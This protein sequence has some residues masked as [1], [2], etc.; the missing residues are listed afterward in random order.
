MKKS[1]QARSFAMGAEIL[2]DRSSVHFRVWA[3]DH[4]S[5]ELILV[6]EIPACPDCKDLPP[7]LILEKDADGYF[8]GSLPFITENILYGFRLDGSTRCYPDPASRFQPQGVNGLSRIIDHNSYTWNDSEWKGITEDN[9]VIYEVHIGTFTSEG[10]WEAARKQLPELA[11][12]GITVIELLPIAEFQ[13]RFNW[14]YDGIFQFAPSHH[15]GT[16]DELR[17]F[18]DQAHQCGIGVILDVVYN[19]LGWGADL[20]SEF[21]KHYFTKKYKNE[22]GAAINFDD[23]N[24]GPVREYFLANAVYWIQEYHFDG[25]RIDATQQIFDSSKNNI[26]KEIVQNVR[27]AAKSKSVFVIAENECQDTTLFHDYRIDAVWSDDFHRSSTVALTGHAEAYYSDYRGRPQEFISAAKYG[28]LYQGQYY[29]WQKKTRGTSALDLPAGYFI[30]YLQNHDQIANSLRGLR[31][32]A[33]C[34]PAL[35]KAFTLLL[36]LG[37]QIPLIFQGQEFCSSA[38]F[39]F[40][41][42]KGETGNSRAARGRKMFLSQF[43]SI[44]AASGPLVPDPGDPQAF[45]KCKLNFEERFINRPI[46]LFHKD[47]LSIR[48]REPVFR[49]NGRKSVDGAVI[50]DNA[51]LLRYSGMISHEDR[52]LIVNLGKDFS[53]VPNPEPLSAPPKGCEWKE[54]ISS[55][56]PLYGGNSTFPLKMKGAMYIPGHSA[57][58]VGTVA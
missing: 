43:P 30:H 10:T 14:G 25:F 58:F 34:D 23:C 50:G 8:S 4:K 28:Y 36:L 15:Y 56:D 7:S 55:E 31:I 35:Y 13:G 20:F 6:P 39:Y 40:F 53:L 42:N 45:Q 29:S 46:Y 16:P 24:C 2:P 19:H 48:K 32:H 57:F 1:L 12:L 44:A 37:P 51:F 11:S 54:I 9:R 21:S 17:S 27:A 22:W 38:P 41:T 18:I 47:L 52:L 3:P 26:I 33:I 49:L 5:A